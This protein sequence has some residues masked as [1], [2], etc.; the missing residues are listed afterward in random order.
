MARMTMIEAIR[1][2]MD[3]MMGRDEKVV[4]YGEDVGYFGGVFRTTQGLQQKYGKTRCFDA[5][6]SE[7]GIVGTA[8]GMATYGLASLIVTPEE[9]R[10]LAVYAYSVYG[11]YFEILGTSAARIGLVGAGFDLTAGVAK[12]SEGDGEGVLDLAVS[13]GTV[14]GILGRGAVVPGVGWLVAGTTSLYQIQFALDDAERAQHTPADP[15][16]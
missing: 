16:L 11:D 8:I 14:T 1:D 10:P 6:I 4:V 12:L 9:G 13:G 2:A 15:V 5:P 3:V 7:A